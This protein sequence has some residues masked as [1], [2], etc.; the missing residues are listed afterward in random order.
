M[1]SLLGLILWNAR[2]IN[3]NNF[4]SQFG[5]DDASLGWLVGCART[6]PYRRWAN[7][8]MVMTSLHLS[9]VWLVGDWWLVMMTR[10]RTHDAEQVHARLWMSI[11]RQRHSG[12]LWWSMQINNKCQ[13]ALHPVTQLGKRVENRNM[14][15]VGGSQL[16]GCC[17]C[18]GSQLPMCVLF[19]RLLLQHWTPSSRWSR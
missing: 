18:L 14:E 2:C 15:W 13:F 1:I 3:N 6:W 11:S 4:N 19:L 12:L 5:P 16:A 10:S 9:E 8:A 7:R 17:C